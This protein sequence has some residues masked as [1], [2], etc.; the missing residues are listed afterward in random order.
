MPCNDYKAGGKAKT[1][2]TV[3]A[4]NK[5]VFVICDSKAKLANLIL[6]I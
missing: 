1:S 2:M 5:I 6:W 4:G 3:F